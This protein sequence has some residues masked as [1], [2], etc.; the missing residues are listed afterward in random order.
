MESKQKNILV[1][2]G[3]GFIGSHIV[4]KL[5]D[6]QYK[7]RV[8]DIK[9][10]H[11]NDIDFIQGSIVS[12]RDI[13]KSVKGIDAVFHFGGFS[14][15]DL[16][17]SHPLETVQLNIWGTTL[18]L[19]ECYKKKVKRFILASS[20]YVNEDKGHL[21]TASKRSA[22]LVCASYNKL[23]KLPYTIL[24]LATAYGPRSRNKD[25]ISI[26]VECILNGK[27]IVIH[28]DGKQK[29]NFIFVED[30][31]NG[32]VASL[33]QKGENK[34]FILAGK[35]TISIKQLAKTI[36]KLT[37]ND[38]EI[39]Y[40]PSKSREDDYCGYVLNQDKFQKEIGW[41]P[42]VDIIEGIKKYIDWYNTT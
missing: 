26:F 12:K 11:R 38:I 29:R 22:E 30:L 40:N 23:Y 3:S 36:I 27:N 1:T 37:K 28:G 35:E 34:T 13:E 21:Y 25:V 16:V 31:A 33:K 41:S 17:K 9:E 7:V 24:Q 42:K 8:L 6:L 10:P 2:G 14:N 19:E 15:I 20:V 18:L 5:I 39:N 4:D 32:C